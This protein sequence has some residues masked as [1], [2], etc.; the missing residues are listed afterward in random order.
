MQRR[1]VLG[2]L[3]GVGVLF[4][5]SQAEA[6]FATYNVG[7]GGL[8]AFN[9]TWDTTTENAFAGGILMT[10]TA[11]D[12]SMAA[13]FMT[14]CTDIG[15]TL[16]LGYNYSYSQP[17]VFNGL[18]GLRP[19]WG[20]TAGDAAAAIQAAANIFYTHQG[21][22]TSGSQ[23]E[24]SALQLAVWEALYDTGTGSTLGLGDGRFRVNSGDAAAITLAA[25]WLSQVDASARYAG[26]L[27]VPDPVQQYG[28][29]GQEVFYNVTPVP[30]PT[31]LIAGALLLLPFGASTI[32]ILRRK[33]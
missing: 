2:C 6:A 19:T 4:L 21:V 8:Q 5:A 16:F 17:Q 28:L 25:T 14:V 11:G 23:A 9:V 29:F 12:P 33:N 15:G 22:L 31:T 7:N 20:A 3:L 18:T 30:E 27:L 32:R 26:F 1:N 10:R 13:S 24:R